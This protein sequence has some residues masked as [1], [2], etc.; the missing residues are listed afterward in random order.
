MQSIS[1]VDKRQNRTASPCRSIPTRWHLNPK[2]LAIDLG[3]STG[4]A[5]GGA[6]TGL[7]EYGTWK[8]AEDK[9]IAAWGKNRLRRRNDP[10]IGRL[11]QRLRLYKDSA[12]IVIFE[13]VQF[14][15]STYQ[16]Q[17]WASFRGAV[18]CAFHTNCF[19]LVECVPTGTLKLFATGNGAAGKPLMEAALFRCESSIRHANLDDNGI[20]AIW[21]WKWAQQHLNN[22]ETSR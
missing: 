14:S 10:R 8:L 6:A 2:I 7:E 4:Y 22:V 12:D 13:D 15:S 18:W 16:T 21:L 17:L 19:P 3:T 11:F 20:D 5:F 1:R 9:E